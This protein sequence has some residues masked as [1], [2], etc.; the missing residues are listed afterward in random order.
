MSEQVRA[1]AQKTLAMVEEVNAI[2]LPEP[3]DAAAVVPLAEADA[4]V[5]VRAG[6][7]TQVRK[8]RWQ[9]DS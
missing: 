5:D 9:A 1:E 7:T 6:S 4:P 3:K 2:V 8:Y